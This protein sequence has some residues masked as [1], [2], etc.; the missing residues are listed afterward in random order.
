MNVP[1]PLNDKARDDLFDRGLER[2]LQG[3]PTGIEDI[4]PELQNVSIRMVQL[5]NDAGWIGAEP[6]LTPARPWWRNIHTVINVAAAAMVIGLVGMLIT[7]GLRVWAPG[8]RQFGSVVTPETV[9]ENRAAD[10]RREPRTDAEIAAIVHKSED[11]VQPFRKDSAQMDIANHTRQITRD[12]NA[13][14][15]DGDFYRAMAYESDYFIWLL[16][17]EVYPAGTG[18]ETDPEIAAAIAARHA[19]IV[20]LKISDGM[21]LSIYSSDRYRIVQY[22]DSDARLQGVDI[23][24]VPL[25]TS[26]DWIEWPT[27]MSMEWDGTEWVIVSATRDGVPP[28]PYFREDALPLPSTP[29]P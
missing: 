6:E 17:Q 14:L 15:L 28:S 22:G 16:G 11:S 19:E 9:I 4:E 23:W 24:L 2:L 18:T 29:A 25:D 26:G 12:W 3:D 5:A 10:C 20:P 8:E 27:V 1:T 13:C 21:N 7:V